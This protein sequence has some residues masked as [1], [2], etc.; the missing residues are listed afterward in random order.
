MG[1]K[2]SAGLILPLLWLVCTFGFSQTQHSATV[3]AIASP[4]LPSAGSGEP[5]REDNDL[6]SHLSADALVWIVRSGDSRAPV[7]LS[8]LDASIRNN[9]GAN[10]ARSA[11]WQ[12]Q[13]KQVVIDGPKAQ[14]RIPQGAFSLFVQYSK[15][16][17]N[18]VKKSSPSGGFGYAIVKL[19]PEERVRQVASYEFSRIAGAP[20][21][22]QADIETKQMPVADDRWLKVTPL[23]P[24]IPGE[25][26]LVQSIPGKNGYS[27]W[28]FDFGVDP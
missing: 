3:P 7:P 6:A 24:L 12:K 19:T 13:R 28:V 18:E 4:P 22:K 27:Q 10:I 9:A 20:K 5:E 11:L 25:Y 14:T 2:Q 16:E 17:E 8:H 15:A 1:M 21:L 23:Q 26:A